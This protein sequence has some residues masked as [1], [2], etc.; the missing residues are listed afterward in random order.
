MQ[1]DGRRKLGKL[2]PEEVDRFLSESHLA[3]LAC[4]DDEGWPYV[5][6]TWHEWDGRRFLVVARKKSVWARYLQ[7]RPR[8]AITVDEVGGLRRVVAQ[9]VASIVE[10]PNVGGAWVA[11]AERM[12]TRYL[13]A[14]GPTY[15]V[16][17]LDRPRWL[18]AL[19]PRR[20]WTWQSSDWAERYKN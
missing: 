18:I 2:H 17:T 13:G 19:D 4:L 11:V 9:C 16:P 14:D 1:D 20:V 3:R 5:V 10:E 7:A 6:P 12:A 8:C 15:L